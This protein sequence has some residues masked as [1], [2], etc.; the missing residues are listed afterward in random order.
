MTAHLHYINSFFSFCYYVVWDMLNWCAEREEQR[1]RVENVKSFNAIRCIRE[2]RWSFHI[3]QYANTKANFLNFFGENSFH[4]IFSISTN[5]R[6]FSS[7]DRLFNYNECRRNNTSQQLVLA[8][9]QNI[10]RTTTT[11]IFHNFREVFPSSPHKTF[12][13]RK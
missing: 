13:Q 12:T 11:Y 2:M 10:Q 6:E 3:M 1:K 9:I 5:S 8:E 7:Y 4:H